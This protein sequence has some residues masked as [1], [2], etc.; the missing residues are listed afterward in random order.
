MISTQPGG[1]SL[2]SFKVLTLDPA[3]VDENLRLSEGCDPGP[4]GEQVEWAAHVHFSALSP[5]IF[6]S[7]C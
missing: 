2:A 6:F 1:A 3:A 5:L 4:Y 7:F